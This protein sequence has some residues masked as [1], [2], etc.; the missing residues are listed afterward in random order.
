MRKIK[1]EIRNP[2]SET[3]SNDINS[4]LSKSAVL[5]FCY[6]NFEFILYFEF[7]ASDLTWTAL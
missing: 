1:F 7:R 3:N 6:S 5:N 2:K 4:K